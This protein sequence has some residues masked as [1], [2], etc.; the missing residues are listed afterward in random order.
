MPLI[1]ETFFVFIT[2]AFV[3]VVAWVVLRSLKRLR[4]HSP[5]AHSI[6]VLAV[7]AI[8]Q[9]EKALVLRYQNTNYLVLSSASGMTLLDKFE[10]Q[11][12]EIDDNT[13]FT[14]A[15]SAAESKRVS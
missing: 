13:D 15:L 1:A 9:R 12:N 8:G 2:T 11:D 6:E 3:L 5:S 4:L 14:A 10:N 7:R